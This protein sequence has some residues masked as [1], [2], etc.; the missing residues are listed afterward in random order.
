LNERVAWERTA[1]ESLLALARTDSSQAR[2][3]VNAVYRLAEAGQGDIRKLEGGSGDWR[4]RIGDWR[5]IFAREGGALHV[6]AVAN[7]GDAYR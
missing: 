3:I 7:R 6:L 4:L 5:V 2:R 1:L